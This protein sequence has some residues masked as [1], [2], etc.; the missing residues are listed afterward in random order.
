MLLPLLLGARLS[1]A[2]SAPPALHVSGNHFVDAKGATVQLRGVNVAGLEF[3]AVQGW[4]PDNPWG[5]ATGEPTPNWKSMT[6]WKVNVVRIPLNEASWLGKPCTM[7]DGKQ[8]NPDPGHNYHDTVKRAVD[9]ASSAGLYVILDLHWNAPN[10][11]CPLAQNPMADAEGSV[12]FWTQVAAEFKGKPNVLFE[13]FNEPYFFW[14][15]GGETPWGVMRDGGTLTQYVTGDAAKYQIAH[16]WKTAGMQGLLDA[17]RSTGATNIVLVGAPS[18]SQD[19]S[20]WV[21]YKPD[22]PLKQ[23]A[24]VWHAYPNSGTPGDA[25]AAQPKFGDVAFQWTQAVLDAGY[26]VVISEFG[27]HNAPGTTDAPF[28]SRLLP[29]AD[30]HGASYLG[31]AWDAWQDK[32]NVLIKNSA[33]DPTDGYGVYV[34]QHLLCVASGK[35]P[36]R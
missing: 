33:G 2:E 18:W 4:L 13:L 25:K 7:V 3:V 9:G 30:Q 36:C 29:W 19:L 31:W 32:N 1:C 17:V 35:P 20:E 15:T 34:K 10:G 24:A 12:A 27:D 22:D 26:P 11:A 28:V 21:A 16:D 14:L 5:G 8:R 23:I 6:R